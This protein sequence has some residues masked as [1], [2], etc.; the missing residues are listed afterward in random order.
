[1]VA[2]LNGH[3]ITSSMWR[4]E[5]ILFSCQDCCSSHYFNNNKYDYKVLDYVI[6]LQCYL[7]IFFGLVG[8]S[9]CGINLLQS[10]RKIISKKH[11]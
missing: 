6:V 11:L 5:S 10:V 9:L 1:M 3:L 7:L 4:F 8:Y 2:A